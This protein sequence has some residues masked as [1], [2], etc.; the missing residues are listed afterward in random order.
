M[1]CFSSAPARPVMAP[2]S[3]RCGPATGSPTPRPPKRTSRC[4][5][6]SPFGPTGT[7]A[8][9]QSPLSP[10]RPFS[11]EVGRAARRPHP[12]GDLTIQKAI[13]GCRT[14][15]VGAKPASSATPSEPTSERAST[16]EAAA[17]PVMLNQADP[18]ASARAFV[19]R[20]YLVDGLLAL[21]RHAGVFYAHQPD[22]GAYHDLD[23]AAV[24]AALLFLPGRRSVVVRR[25]RPAAADPQGVPSH[26]EQSRQRPR[27]VACR[28]PP[29]RLLCAA[30]L[31]AGQSRARSVRSGCLSQRSAAHPDAP[32]AAS[33]AGV[34]HAPCPGLPGRP[35]RP[36]TG[37][38]APISER[39]VACGSRISRHPAGVDRLLPDPEHF[40]EKIGL[41]VGPRTIRQKH[42]RP[43][44]APS[45]R[46]AAHL[47]GPRLANLSEQFGLSILV[48]DAAPSSRMRASA[49]APIPPCSPSGCSRFR[50]GHVEHS[51]QVSARLDREA[52]HA[53]PAHDQRTAADRGRLGALA[54]RFLVLTLHESFYGR[55]DHGLF[56][57]F[58]PELPGILNWALRGVGS[59]L[60]AWAVRPTAVGRR[61]GPGV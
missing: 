51:A 44:H 3:Q 52:H 6:S 24:R 37:P 50:G 14:C 34:V 7:P 32:A 9:S 40:Q 30:L 5:A 23:D 54:S 20:A 10:Q 22:L 15:D 19:T 18:L 13:A 57:R 59:A 38:L 56:E 31:A 43:G 47:S 33:H 58:L 39:A 8:A 2:S 42:G 60:R 35:A 28:V 55:E 29:A 26:E 36:A 16:R 11:G 1:P 45:P 17:A 61:S 48:A 41:L 25:E 27:C 49:A 46:R 21:R 53:V 4:A 12:L